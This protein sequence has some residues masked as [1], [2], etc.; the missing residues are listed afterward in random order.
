MIFVTHMVLP[1]VAGYLADPFVFLGLVALL[2]LRIAC[3]SEHRRNA[4]AVALA[5]LACGNMVAVLVPMAS[6][7]AEA[8]RWHDPT[9]EINQAFM[10]YIGLDRFD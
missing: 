3:T 5:C 2:A 4:A 6:D 7:I 9:H 8:A 10:Q 1:L